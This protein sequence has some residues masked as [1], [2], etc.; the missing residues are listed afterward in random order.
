MTQPVILHTLPGGYTFRADAILGF[1]PVYIVDTSKQ[2]NI[3]SIGGPPFRV[4]AACQV[5]ISGTTP[6]S[7][8]LTDTEEFQDAADVTD[9]VLQT[10]RNDGTK[11]RDKLIKAIWP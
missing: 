4:Y 7:I 2:I 9:P 8:K 10:H 3:L 5:Y 1:G 6:F 11:K